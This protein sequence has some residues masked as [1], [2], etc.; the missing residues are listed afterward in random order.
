V[1]ALAAQHGNLQHKTL[2]GDGAAFVDDYNLEIQVSCRADA[3]NP[4]EIQYALITML[5]VAGKVGM[6]IYV[7]V[8]VHVHTARVGCPVGMNR[9]Q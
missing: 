3:R 9:K 8:R 2:E 4:E 7:K 1:D 5:E 6:P